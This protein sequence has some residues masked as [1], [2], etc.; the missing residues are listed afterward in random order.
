M[1]IKYPAEADRKKLVVAA[2]EQLGEKPVYAGAPSLN[3]IVG[4]YAIACDRTLAGPDDR[5][6]VVALR[7]QGYEPVEETYE[8][9]FV[10][11][12][13]V[14]AERPGRLAIEVSVDDSFTPAKMA[15]LEKLIASRETLLK[16]VLGVDALPIEQIDEVLRSPW[17]PADENA[18]VYSQLASALVRVA[19][20]AT[21]ITAR[22]QQD[23][24]SDKFRMRTYLLKLGF[25][26]DT[27]KQAR[28]ILTRG[29]SGNGSYAKAKT[30]EQEGCKRGGRLFGP[31]PA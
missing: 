25:I 24:A 1:R 11:P 4:S 10:E 31:P 23:C 5:G 29:L 27:Y 18:T 19:T 26:G 17:F 7:E 12:E 13:A 2:A 21:R 9:E 6:L 15:N 3:Y 16:K 28:K 14:E 20:E 22:E 30:S 8:A